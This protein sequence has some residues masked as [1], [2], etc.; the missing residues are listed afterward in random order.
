MNSEGASTT[1]ATS[2]SRTS[3]SGI[4]QDLSDDEHDSLP[5][6]RLQAS[7]APDHASGSRK[8]W[9]VEFQQY[10]NTAEHVPPGMSAVWWWG[11]SI[12]VCVVA[13]IF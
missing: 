3:S 9:L 2:V 5:V 13:L 10:V 6:Q 8:P 11:V 1:P 4:I 12:S 7:A